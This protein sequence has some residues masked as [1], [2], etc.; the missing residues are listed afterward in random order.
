MKTL[1]IRILSN[2]FA[3]LGLMLA[4][5]GGRGAE[6]PEHPLSSDYRRAADE[7]AEALQDA[8]PKVQESLLIEA[9]ERAAACLPSDSYIAAR[10]RN[11]KSRMAAGGDHSEILSALQNIVEDLR[12]RPLA[13]ADLPVGFPPCTPVGEVEVKRYPGYRAAVTRNNGTAFWRLFAHIKKN[14]VAM[15]A[16]VEMTLEEN[17]Q[18]PV[19]MA[20][21][22]ER[23]DQGTAGEDGTVEVRDLPGGWFVSTGIRGPRSNQALQL[24]RQRVEEWVGHHGDK[25]EIAGP[26]RL[27]GYNS[28]FIPRDKYY[29]EYQV[30]VRE[31][32]SADN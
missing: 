16:P 19:L 9:I 30:P 12:F 5:A 11:L 26:P 1:M 32:S 3:F 29:W 6:F 10:L 20:F 14:N 8:K 31:K 23:P 28:P 27:L 7:L 2:I 4:G 17:G 18:R 25:W 22:Y 21:L 24:A 15:T 13:E